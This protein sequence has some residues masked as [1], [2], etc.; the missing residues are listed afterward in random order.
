MIIWWTTRRGTGLPCPSLRSNSKPR[1]HPS[2]GQSKCSIGVSCDMPRSIIACSS[3]G[4]MLGRSKGPALRTSSLRLES[5]VMV[6][7]GSADTLA[8]SVARRAMRTAL[9][10]N[11]LHSLNRSLG[12]L[13]GRSPRP[14]LERPEGLP[15]CATSEGREAMS[16]K[17]GAAWRALVILLSA[18]GI[19]AAQQRIFPDVPSFERPEASP[20]VHGLAA[21]LLSVRRGDSRFGREPEAEVALG[22]NFPVVALRQGASP[23][24]LGIG[25]QVYAR[26]SL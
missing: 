25:S 14:N 24:T 19:G 22:E 20:R 6:T 11:I 10:T 4:G 18:P 2:M 9:Q 23:I 12:S 16:S 21:R 7:L 1:S 26:F 3:I 8:V 13:H 15:F 17:L 5:T